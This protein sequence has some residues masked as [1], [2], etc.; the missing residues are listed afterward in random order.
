MPEITRLCIG[1]A[2]SWLLKGKQGYLLVDSG[3]PSKHRGL[4]NQLRALKISPEQIR[5]AV[6]THVHFDHVGNLAA[7]VKRCGCPVVV[8]E[9]EADNL[10]QGRWD[11]PGGTIPFT[12]GVVKLGR[13]FPALTAR[14]TRY[15]AVKPDMRV[16]A[17]MSLE[18]WGFEASIL[19]TPG[20]TEG[21]L[22]VLTHDGHAMV[23][24]LAYNEIPF[25][26][27]SRVPPFGNDVDTLKKSWALLLENGV[28]T[29]C[30]G[31][32][33]AFDATELV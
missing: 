27:K 5:L 6:A 14:V 13:R 12:K 25:L 10:E 3:V 26:Y 2:N 31:H 30:P 1:F 29:V 21:S 32:G 18:P 17:P 20:H 11:L 7:L 19:P 24:D 8:H 33:A 15:E 16:S 22:S 28:R 9:A 4:F 23:G